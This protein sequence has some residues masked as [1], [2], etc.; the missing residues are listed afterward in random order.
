MPLVEMGR[1]PFEVRLGSLLACVVGDDTS[2][3]AGASPAGSENER[4]DGSPGVPLAA[5]GDRILSE[6]EG[7]ERA[8]AQLESRLL[9][10]YGALHT[11]QEQQ[12][13]WS[14]STTRAPI[15]SDQVV[16]HEIACA[17]GVGPGEVSRR[18][19]LALAPRRH[20]VLRDAMRKG[21]V[22]LYRALQVVAEA[23]ALSDDTLPEL[24][25]AVLAPAPDGSV[26][27]QRLFASRLRR[28]VRSAD[29]RSPGERH[30]SARRRR[31]AFG[32][33]TDDGMGFITVVASAERVVGALDRVDS[34]ARSARAAGDERTLDQLRSDLLTE[35]AL[36]GTVP[37]ADRA[38]ASADGPGTSDHVE[39]GCAVAGPTSPVAGP[40]CGRWLAA[41][42]AAVVRIVVPFEVAV[43]ASGAAC[44]LPG[45]GWVTAEHARRIMTGAGAVWQRLAVDVDTGRAL[46]LSTD[47]YAPTAAMVEHVRAVDGV[48]RAPGCQVPADR[49]DLDHA[50]PWPTGSTHVT[51]LQSLSRRCHNLKTT[52]VWTVERD[53]EET[54][55][56]TLA[57]REYV[58]YPKD[59]RE[60]LTGPDT[61]PPRAASGP[62][63]PPPF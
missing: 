51:N 24:E 61:H 21:S 1:S 25:A 35:L 13:R 46:E 11:V 54:R 44:E 39:E 28:C 26:P 16:T 57:G 41:A 52:G 32:R 49:G 55:W 30:C 20:R 27:S 38:S 8:K 5:S 15:S 4:G 62:P 47:R 60:A 59:W 34:L 14:T 10:A 29:R 48:C 63:P 22:G 40:T 33:L 6:I 17:T 43:G 58:T 9:E 2:V 3:R 36:F 31:T 42:P 45:H 23:R 56:T 53:D 7:L 18:L 37:E 50:I 12:L 19:E